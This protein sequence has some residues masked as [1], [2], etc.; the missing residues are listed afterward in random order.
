MTRQIEML[1]LKLADG[2]RVVRFTEPASGVSLEKKLDPDMSV[3]KQT[4]R[5]KAAF[6]AFLE[7]ETGTAG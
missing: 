2:A 5:W 4:D 7:R 3:A 6:L 1:S